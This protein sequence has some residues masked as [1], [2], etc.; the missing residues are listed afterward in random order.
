MA[1]GREVFAT[2]LGKPRLTINDSENLQHWCRTLGVTEDQLRAAVR[3]VRV[4]ECVQR[5]PL[6]GV[7]SNVPVQ[8]STRVS[9]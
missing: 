9:V 6:L 8:T 4:L 1:E 5:T 7:L 2:L 3:A